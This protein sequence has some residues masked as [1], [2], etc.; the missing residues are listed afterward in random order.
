M[1]RLRHSFRESSFINNNKGLIMRK[2]N[3]MRRIVLGLMGLVVT[4]LLSGYSAAAQ[5]ITVASTTSTE[6]SGLF[7][8]ILPRFENQTGIEVR[9]VAVGTGQAIEIAGRGDADVLFVHHK[10]SEEK[11]VEEGYGVKRYDVMYNDYVI[12]GPRQDPADIG[13]MENASAALQKIAAAQAA[14]VSRGDDSGTHKME[15]SLWKVADVDVKAASG[16]WYREVGSGMGAALNTTSS[17]N[18]YTLADRGTWISFKNKGNLEILVEGDSRLFNQYG[19]ILVNPERHPHV[20]AE[21]GQQFID[22]LIS[23]EGQ[24]AIASYKLDGKQLFFPNAG[25]SC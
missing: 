3:L 15:L 2:P 8:H 12:V 11:F 14:F 21:S 16:N 7:G 18:A 6:A 22:W 10:L 4:G 9:V 1:P 17:L 25:K 24:Q 23:K 13:G 5:Y 20:K 19:V